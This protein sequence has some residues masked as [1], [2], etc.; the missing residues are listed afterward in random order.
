MLTAAA[1]VGWGCR[2][3]GLSSIVGFLLAGLLVRPIAG[4]L[5]IAP[6]EESVWLAAQIGLIFLMF[7]IGLRMSFSKL[8]RLGPGMLIATLLSCGLMYYLS[9]LLGAALGWGM[10]ESFFLAGMLTVSSGNIIARVLQEKGATHERYGQLAMGISGFESVVAIVFLAVLSSIEQVDAAAHHEAAGR[11]LLMLAAFLLLAVVGG[12]LIVPWLLR[13]ISVTTDRGL[14][15]LGVAGLLFALSAIGYWAGYSL[16]LGAYLLGTIVA[17][18][19]H[20][21][22]I[23]RSFEGMRWIFSAV[24]CVAVGMQ[25]ELH[26]LWESLGLILLVSAFTLIARPLAC[27]TALTFTGVASKDALRTGFSVTPIGEFSFVLVQLG[28]MV[29]AIPVKFYPLVVGVS[30]L[31][32]L[33]APLLAGRVDVMTRVLIDNQPQWLRIWTAL[34]RSWLERLKIQSQRNRFW[35]LSR[36]RFIQ[37]GI[38]M[39][40]VSVVLFFSK[41][42][43]VSVEA[44]LGQDWLF[45]NGPETMFWIGLSLALLP[46]LV[47]IWRNVSAL[48]L[49][50]SQMIVTRSA[51]S[52]RLATLVETS[53]K[54][55]VGAGLGIWLV[56]VL[57]AGGAARWLLLASAVVAVLGLVLLRQK[58]I[59]WHSRFEGDLQEALATDSPQIAATALGLHPSPDWDLKIVDCTVPDIADCIGKRIAELDLRARF[60]SAVVAFERQGLVIPLPPPDTMIY[61]GDKILLLGTLEQVAGARRFLTKV[62]VHAEEESFFEEIGLTVITVPAW[63]AGCGR[64]LAELSLTQQHGVQVAGIHR[65][66]V[67]MLNPGAEE[68]IQAGDEILALGTGQQI[69]SFRTWL[70][71]HP[72]ET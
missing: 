51:R 22:S 30:I 66:D 45:R 54:V 52:G 17:G 36:K 70:C 44:W 32:N 20:R 48:A 47:A 58:L 69:D 6:R 9:R 11:T 57:P 19:P 4:F 60:G 55:I 23:E 25:V 14:K 68:I 2:L 65:G 41:Q 64:S 72:D 24:F 67:R 12:T 53:I 26:V 46:P 42:I 40:L 29:A 71:E 15:T 38:E 59:Y 3:L 13:R 49:I 56:A 61:P 18:T 7:F 62:S 28:V 1:L 35:Q 10:Q 21:H 63:S 34:Y 16:A 50:Y 8:R 43:L 33:A 27:A 31:T 39:A 5:H 37:I